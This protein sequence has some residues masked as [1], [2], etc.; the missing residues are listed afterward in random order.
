MALCSSSVLSPPT[1]HAQQQAGGLFQA[2]YIFNFTKYISFPPSRQ[3]GDFVIGIIGKT[4]TQAQLE[5]TAQVKRVPLTGQAIR[6]VNLDDE[7][8]VPMS[9]CH[10]IYI[11]ERY[12][13]RLKSVADATKGKPVLIVSEGAGLFAQGSLISFVFNSEK[14]FEIA[15]AAVEANNMKVSSEL[16]R[17]AAIVP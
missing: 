7:R 15:R 1:M 16:L 5:K 3:T 17:V 8:D 11:P 2:L 14:K 6:V 4:D 13:K 12:V 9:D 10:I